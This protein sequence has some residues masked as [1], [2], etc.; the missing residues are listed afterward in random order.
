MP[1]A[2]EDLKKK[3]DG[4]AKQ[5]AEPRRSGLGKRLSLGRGQESP[6]GVQDG[7]ERGVGALGPRGHDALFPRALAFATE[8]CSLTRLDHLSAA[9]GAGL[10][11]VVAANRR[12]WSRTPAAQHLGHN[13]VAID[14]A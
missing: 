11:R 2:K 4:L 3:I 5:I 13:P 12:P 9:G 6:R 10:W 7:T 8:N 1:E 14:K